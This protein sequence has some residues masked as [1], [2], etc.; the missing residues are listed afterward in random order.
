MK[1]VLTAIIGAVV[2]VVA[3]HLWAVFWRARRSSHYRCS[4]NAVA[5]PVVTERV[6]SGTFVVSVERA[7]DKHRVVWNLQQPPAGDT[8]L[9]V[10]VGTEPSA[11]TIPANTPLGQVS[12]LIG[13]AA[14]HRFSATLQLDAHGATTGICLTSGRAGSA[15]RLAIAGIGAATLTDQNGDR[16]DARV[17]VNGD[18]VATTN[19]FVSLRDDVSARIM[20]AGTTSIVVGPEADGG[21]LLSGFHMD[22]SASSVGP[23]LVYRTLRLQLWAGV[24]LVAAGGL[25]GMYYGTT[26][27]SLKGQTRALE[28]QA[29]V[30]TTSTSMKGSTTT[31]S[32]ASTTTIPGASG[33]PTVVPTTGATTGSVTAQNPPTPGGTTSST[34]S[35][36]QAIALAMVAAG[37]TMIPTGAV[38]LLAAKVKEE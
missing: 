29:G 27:G 5:R 16:L 24:A 19:D 3:M 31:T 2:L 13:A 21:R 11:V 9:K 28:A 25:G 26:Q 18:E 34:V 14:G 20:A 12:A 8:E 23:L 15:G 10:T 7:P 38:G 22:R 36:V 35:L 30:T 37:A 32:S 33:Q 6:E 1:A 4:N 17:L